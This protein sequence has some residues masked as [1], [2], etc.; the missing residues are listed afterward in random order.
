MTSALRA[1]HATLFALGLLALVFIFAGCDSD[2]LDGRDYD[3]GDDPD[4][5][6]Q[7]D[8]R[9]INFSLNDRDNRDDF[10]FDRDLS[11]SGLE[12][13]YEG[14]FSALTERAVDDGLVLLYASDQTG[15]GGIDGLV[16]DGWTAL[17]ITL[18]FDIDNDFFVDYTLATTYTYDIGRL[19]VNLVASNDFSEEELAISDAVLQN[20]EGIL[21]KL[22]VVPG[23]GLGRG[24]IDYADYEAVKR[25]YNLPD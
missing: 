13:Q 14:A 6:Y 15:P 2:S 18:G 12:V 21:F 25:A 1:R 11:D 16:R 24:G 7:N 4:I 5:V 10:I 22:V 8:I 9:V 3:H 17:P 23:G 19:Y 20:V